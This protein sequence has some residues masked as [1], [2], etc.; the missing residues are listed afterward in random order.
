VHENCRDAWGYVIEGYP[1]SIKQVEEIQSQL[2]RLDLAILVDCTEQ[3]CRH[4][5]QKRWK[6]AGQRQT[7]RLGLQQIFLVFLLLF[8]IRYSPNTK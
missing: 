1:R 4:S 5:V 7:E 3:F 8:I 2:G 6:L